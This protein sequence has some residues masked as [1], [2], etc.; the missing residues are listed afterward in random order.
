MQDSSIGIIQYIKSGQITISNEINNLN[1]GKDINIKVRDFFSNS[2][3]YL[4][5]QKQ[6]DNVQK[7]LQVESDMQKRVF[8]DDKLNNLLELQKTFKADVLRLAEI[9]SKMELRTERLI[10]AAALFEQGRFKDADAILKEED[11][12]NDQ[13][14]LLLYV[15]YLELQKNNLWKKYQ[16][17]TDHEQRN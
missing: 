9:F 1:A 14:N 17:L 4:K 3:D 8:L 15:D 5:L 12:T 11:L 2:P 16:D 13:F 7:Q 6:I 10:K